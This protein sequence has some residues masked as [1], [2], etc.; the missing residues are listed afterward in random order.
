MI[1]ST[2]VSRSLPFHGTMKSES[3]NILENLRGKFV[4]NILNAKIILILKKL[5]AIIL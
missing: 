4:S 5:G 1:F 2:Q 3:E